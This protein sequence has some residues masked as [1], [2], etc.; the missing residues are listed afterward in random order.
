MYLY[1]S[2]K[3]TGVMNNYT[4]NNIHVFIWFIKNDRRNEYLYM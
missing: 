4:C 3:M 2:L 1:G